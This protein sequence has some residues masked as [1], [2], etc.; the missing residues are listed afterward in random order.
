MSVLI[1]VYIIFHNFLEIHSTLSENDFRPKFFFFNGFTQLHTPDPLNSQNLLGVT[2]VF[3]Q[4]SLRCPLKYFFSNVDKI[5]QKHLL[6]IISEL[7]LPCIFEGSNYRVSGL[8]FRHIWRTAIL[9]QASIITCKYN[10]SSFSCIGF[11]CLS[12][13]ILFIKD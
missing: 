9:T 7:P 6:C 13:M 2:K 10:F 12:L 5:L 4:S 3:F 8:L 11:T 1:S